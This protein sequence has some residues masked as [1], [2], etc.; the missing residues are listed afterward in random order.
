MGARTKAAALVLAAACTTWP[1]GAGAAETGKGRVLA[2]DVY[3]A[4]KDASP[5]ARQKLVEACRTHLSGHPGTVFFATGVRAE[6]LQRE[7]NDRAY[8]VSLHV[9]FDSQ[10]AH[11]AY[12]EHAR[13]KRFIEENQANWKQVRVFDSWVET[14]KQETGAR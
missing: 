13:H 1:S 10:S 14:A 9:Y 7:V 12:Q 6:A 8:D 11:D 2:H 5:A 4:L 3:F